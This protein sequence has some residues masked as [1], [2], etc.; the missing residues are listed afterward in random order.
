MIDPFRAELTAEY[1]V[2]EYNS[3]AARERLVRSVR[4]RITL[5]VL[6]ASLTRTFGRDVAREPRP[7]IPMLPTRQRPAA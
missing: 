6:L 7:E 5:G 3:R 2:R 1:I 4:P